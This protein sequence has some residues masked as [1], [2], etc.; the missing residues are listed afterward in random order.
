MILVNIKKAKDLHKNADAK[1]RHNEYKDFLLNK[2][3]LRHLID[4]T[5]SKNHKIGTY[6]INKTS[7]SCFDNKNSY[8]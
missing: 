6:E 4:R 5:Q 3:C 7:L 1:I 2:K 8:S